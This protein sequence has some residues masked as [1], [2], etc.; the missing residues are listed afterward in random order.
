MGTAGEQIHQMHLQC[1]VSVCS[2]I[3]EAWRETPL[4]E[5]LQHE[6]AH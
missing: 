6:R 5:K 2:D 3:G 4:V 1:S